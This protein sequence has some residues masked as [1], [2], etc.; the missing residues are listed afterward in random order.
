MSSWVNL[1][2]ILRPGQGID[3][4]IRRSSRQMQCVKNDETV[5]VLIEESGLSSGSAPRRAISLQENC[6]PA[7]PHVGVGLIEKRP[8]GAVSS[9]HGDFVVTLIG[10]GITAE[11]ERHKQVVKTIVED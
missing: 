11:I 1:W 5:P 3:E 9:A 8:V 10:I 2:P 6:P 7:L 4:E